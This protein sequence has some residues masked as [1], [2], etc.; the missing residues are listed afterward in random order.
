MEKL[1]FKELIEKY[2]VV[3]PMLQRDFAYGRADEYEKR[4]NFLRNLKSY[5]NDG[6]PHELDFVYGSVDEKSNLKLLDGQ[7]RITTLFLL[8]WYL[9]LVKDPSGNHHF[10]E[11]KDM[12][13]L[14]D[15]GSRFSYR[16][17]FSSTDFC[18]VLVLLN[19]KGVDYVE[20]Y[21]D[22]IE[23]LP[24][25]YTSENNMAVPYIYREYHGSTFPCPRRT[26]SLISIEYSM[27][28]ARCCHIES[29]ELIAVFKAPEDDLLNGVDAEAL[30]VVL[31]D[32]GGMPVADAFRDV[33]S[34]R[35]ALRGGAFPACITGIS[36]PVKVLVTQVPDVGCQARHDAGVEFADGVG[37][38]AREAADQGR[39]PRLGNNQVPHFL[40]VLKKGL[41]TRVD[42][43]VYMGCGMDA[44]G[45]PGRMGTG[46]AME[47]I[48]LVAG[49][50]EGGFDAV[51]V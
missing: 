19:Y 32:D 29:C 41:F 22:D 14:V 42:F 33:G 24:V 35:V 51:S 46:N 30:D 9:S 1:S 25:F 21:A 17:R 2:V 43:S 11:F 23:D 28:S 31:E 8:H 26:A 47:V 40:K 10:N 3:I 4:E 18:N 5:L 15:G 37:A 27:R 34:D 50:E 7:Q 44:D 48:R 13:S 12:M 39:C 20:K 6:T 49:D 38:P 36:V 45:V 16:T